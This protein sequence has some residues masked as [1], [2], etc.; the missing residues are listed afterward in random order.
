VQ[1]WHDYPYALPNFL[2][3]AIGL[4]A[5]IITLLFVKETLHVHGDKKN[6]ESSMSTRELIKYPGVASVLL[7]YNY[8]M[9]LAYTFTAVFPVT[10]Y[11]PVDLGGFGFSSGQIALCTGLNGVSQAIWLLVAF[12]I[13]HKRFGTGRLLGLCALAW[14][15]LFAAFPIYS[16][17]LQ[18]GE[19][20]IFW[21]T[22]PPMLALFSGVA[23]AFSKNSLNLYYLCY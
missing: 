12:P 20:T 8:V 16:L 2:I 11:I 15:L 7:V 5:A 23:M 9:L 10:Q 6:T 3:A 1:F 13:L 17:L 4:S 18:H 21:A 19:T 14:P 22:A